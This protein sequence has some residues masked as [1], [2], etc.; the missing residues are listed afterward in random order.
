MPILLILV[1]SGFTTKPP[2]YVSLNSSTPDTSAATTTLGL[3]KVTFLLGSIISYSTSA[4]EPIGVS[5]MRI[6]STSQ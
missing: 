6:C 1:S 3:N 5:S 4:N 2:E